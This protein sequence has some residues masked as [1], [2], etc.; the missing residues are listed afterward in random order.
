MAKTEKIT[1]EVDPS[2]L[3]VASQ[4]HYRMA[5]DQEYRDRALT[6]PSGKAPG[7]GDKPADPVPE[8]RNGLNPN[9]LVSAAS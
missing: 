6:P 9:V 1:V 8:D 7:E 4:H 3:G 2:Q 5:N